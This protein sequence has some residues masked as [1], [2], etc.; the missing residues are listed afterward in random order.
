MIA[1]AVQRPASA[2]VGDFRR[3]REG[4]APVPKPRK[5][6]E[7]LVE[8]GVQLVS[9]VAMLAVVSDCSISRV[10]LALKVG[11]DFVRRKLRGEGRG[12]RP[13]A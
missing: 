1:R 12:W 5:R 10:A 7:P 9:A 13:P 8:E 6:L 3:V 2:M 11:L 4:V